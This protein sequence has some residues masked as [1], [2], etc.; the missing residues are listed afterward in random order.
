[1]KLL[2]FVFSLLVIGNASNLKADTDVF[3]EPNF[4]SVQSFLP[5]RISSGFEQ[6][7]PSEGDR[8]VYRNRR[9]YSGQRLGLATR[10]ESSWADLQMEVDLIA[11]YPDEEL[12]FFLGRNAF[13][14]FPI[15]NFE[16]WVGRREFYSPPNQ[17]SFALGRGIDGGE[18][19]G[20]DVRYWENIAIQVFLWDYYRG[21][22]LWEFNQ[23]PV[24]MTDAK[25]D[26]KIGQRYRTGIRSVY[27]NNG[28]K[29][30][31]DFFY[32]NLGNWGQN[33]RDDLRL[34]NTEGGDGDFLYR[35]RVFA[36]V[37]FG[38]MEA[39]LGYHT[40][41]GLDKTFSD[42]KRPERSMPIRGEAIEISLRAE[43]LGFYGEFYGFI[44]NTAETGESLEPLT[45][46]YVGMGS[47]ISRGA[48]FNR[49]VNV[50][51]AAWVT[52]YG[53]EWNQ[54]VLGRRESSAYGRI[55]LGWKRDSI[56]ISL[57]GEYLLPR[58]LQAY[59]RGQ[60]SLQKR[61]YSKDFF[62][63]SGI[64]F[65]YGNADTHYASYLGCDLSYAWTPEILGYRGSIIHAY[66]RFVF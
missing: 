14:R 20:F 58:Q 66:G 1:M 28:V 41:R 33:S 4:F 16:I 40:V 32:L 21:F 3:W 64:S 31:G 57:F 7:G 15:K 6:L 54:G 27:A 30:E 53:L 24:F 43:H 23:T 55:R 61:D 56:E 35:Y 5:E 29:L 51:P 62:A 12:S 46:G 37:S 59:D 25:Q 26:L 47:P 52:E 13:V 11:S 22:P 42:P 45:M 34:R 9:Q 49:E 10:Q 44:P 38:L 63:E 39:G 48:F 19:L 50:Y 18:G 60:I 65:S 36:S 17:Y 2:R 8:S